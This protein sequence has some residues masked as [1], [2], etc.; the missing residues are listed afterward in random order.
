MST[1]PRARV[2]FATVRTFATFASRVRDLTVLSE[3]IPVL[4]SIATLCDGVGISRFEAR[5]EYTSS[6]VIPDMI[7][8]ARM[9]AW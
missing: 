1:N 4:F 5:K 7:E 3:L 6:V 9:H 8:F 2:G